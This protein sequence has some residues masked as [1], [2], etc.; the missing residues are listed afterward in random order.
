VNILPLKQFWNDYSPYYSAL[1]VSPVFQRLVRD[2]IEQAR[3]SQ[4]HRVLDLGCGP[5]YFLPSL[6]Q[7]GASI[8]AVDYSEEM[9]A[10]AEKRVLTTNS[11]ATTS[12]V[13]F[14]LDDAFHFLHS[15]SD[16]M[17]DRVIA[18]LFLSYF[19]QPE[20]LLMHIF[21]VLKPGGRIVMSNPIPNPHF[22][23]VCLK[24]GWTAIQ[25]LLTAIQLLKYAGRIKW[26]GKVGVFH[27]FTYSETQ[28][29]LLD[30]GFEVSSIT[31]TS[32]FADTVFLSTA[33]KPLLR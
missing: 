20:A 4:G 11:F 6:V 7:S 12:Q 33:T 26:L 13:E 30:V 29:L 21:R 31:I 9:L 8:M 18:S 27:F 5:G 3:I 14:T 23:K 1:G 10:R 25:Y 32:S 16:S 17:F 2:T 24:S 15:T 19:P 22:S 28:Q